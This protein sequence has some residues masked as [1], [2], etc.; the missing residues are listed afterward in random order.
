MT[1]AFSTI[2]ANL[3]ERLTYLDLAD[4]LSRFIPNRS[5]EENCLE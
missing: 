1:P 4:P 3:P 2:I 5:G